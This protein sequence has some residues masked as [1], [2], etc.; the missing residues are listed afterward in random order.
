[1]TNLGQIISN[2]YELSIEISL[3]NVCKYKHVRP[4]WGI[5]M[6][7]KPQWEC[8]DGCPPENAESSQ[9]VLRK[10]V[11]QSG[12]TPYYGR[13]GG[14]GGVTTDV[15]PFYCSKYVQRNETNL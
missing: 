9:V 15:Y 8:P 4:L 10:G 1:M 5:I 6:P 13:F 12:L 7:G 3:Q 2:N 14:E 11:I